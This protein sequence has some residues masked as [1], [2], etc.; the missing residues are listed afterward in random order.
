[1]L[2]SNQEKNATL[3]VSTKH[4]S[5][6]EIVIGSILIE[7]HELSKL[8]GGSFNLPISHCSVEGAT[9]KLFVTKGKVMENSLQL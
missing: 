6:K 1:M 7:F 2:S 8:E 9:V 4:R 3:N 5:K